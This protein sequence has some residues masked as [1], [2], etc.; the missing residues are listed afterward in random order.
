MALKGLQKILGLC[1]AC[2]LLKAK[3]L[4]NLPPEFFGGPAFFAEVLKGDGA[5]AFAQAVAI[6]TVPQGGMLDLRSG[7]S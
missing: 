7:L 5:V 4:P 3:H 1:I 2:I 6:R